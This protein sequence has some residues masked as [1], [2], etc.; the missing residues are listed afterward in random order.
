MTEGERADTYYTRWA[1]LYDQ[2]ARRTPG[3]ASLRTETVRRLDPPR[4]G[5]VVEMGCGPGPNFPYLRDAVG[6][7]G[8]V[9]GL[10]VAR[11]AVGRAHRHVRRQG[12]STVHPL[13]AD[14]TRP[15]IASADALLGTFIV[16]M[17]PNPTEVVDGWC[18][19]V[20]PGGRVG[21]LHFSRTDRWHRALSNRGLDL[22]I[23]V[24]TPG[25]IRYH[26][27]R[28]RLLDERVRAGHAQ[29]RT[30]CER[31]ESTRH[32]GGLLVRSVGTVGEAADDP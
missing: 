19:L 30:R 31:I 25:S 29:L 28:S 17:F 15:P 23:T 6:P 32:W 16:G 26:P 24:S 12:W 3:I 7:A 22:L 13:R 4:G 1:A 18:D 11:G 5:T 10:D 8:T 14:A 20:G 21:L 9:I 2:V 27:E